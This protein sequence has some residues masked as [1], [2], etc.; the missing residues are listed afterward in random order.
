MAPIC[1]STSRAPAW[2]PSCWVRSDKILL[3]KA[4]TPLRISDGMATGVSL[5]LLRTLCDL[6]CD[7]ELGF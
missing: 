4:G 6:A 5:L 7:F 3:K 2:E 1:S